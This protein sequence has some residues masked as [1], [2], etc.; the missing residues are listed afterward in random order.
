MDM[1]LASAYDFL[2][3]LFFPVKKHLMMKP[4]GCTVL[5][6]LDMSRCQ[7]IDGKFILFRTV[8][9]PTQILLD[10]L[11]ITLNKR[12]AE[13]G[14]GDL[15]CVSHSTSSPLI[16]KRDIDERQRSGKSSKK[17]LWVISHHH[18]ILYRMFH[19]LGSSDNKHI[20]RG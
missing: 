10:F 4:L 19:L 9:E 15:R 3:N 17:I 2:V 7:I 12:K 5:H 20:E 1:E 18:L 11:K 16:L 14:D 8:G 6:D 13:F